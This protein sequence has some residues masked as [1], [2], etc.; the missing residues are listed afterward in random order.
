MLAPVCGPKSTPNPRNSRR[1]NNS[2]RRTSLSLPGLP[3]GFSLPLRSRLRLDS[4]GCSPTVLGKAP[5]NNNL[6]N[7]ARMLCSRVNLVVPLSVE[8][9]RFDEKFLHLGVGD[10]ASFVVLIFVEPAMNF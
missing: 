9:V 1:C 3:P 4:H 6:P 10:L 8:C 2:L 7:L 5:S